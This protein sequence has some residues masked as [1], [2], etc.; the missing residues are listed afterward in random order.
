MLAALATVVFLSVLWLTTTLAARILLNHG[1]RIAAALSAQA[2]APF[3]PPAI[4]V[5]A[6]ARLRPQW[7][8]TAQPRQRAAA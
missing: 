4:P 5:R 2:R 7:A 3:S 1:Q 6:R 8:A